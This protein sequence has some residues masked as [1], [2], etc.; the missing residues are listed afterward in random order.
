MV[1]AIDLLSTLTTKATK[2][3]KIDRVREV[4][5]LSQE[6]VIHYENS[7]KGGVPRRVGVVCLQNCCRGE[8][9]KLYSQY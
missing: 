4:V 1:H 5:Q 6:P 8:F 2:R 7:A 3:W 9:I